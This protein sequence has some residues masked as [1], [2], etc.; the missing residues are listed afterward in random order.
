MMK[1]PSH[2]AH[3]CAEV[4]DV[5]RL[6]D[7]DGQMLSAADFRSEQTYF[8]EKLKLHNRCLHGYGV[9]CGL[10]I[11]AVTEESCCPPE[12]AE[13]LDAIREKL[14]QIEAAIDA[15]QGKLEADGLPKDEKKAILKEIAELAA[16]REALRRE[17]EGHG[18]P[19][20]DGSEPCHEDKPSAKVTVQCG[21]ALDCH[22]NEL[23][24]RQAVRV[25][26]WAVL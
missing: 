17:R 12:D 5:E 25:D 18:R 21:L 9:V 11:T 8:R 6:S 14:R 26:L 2:A 22:G 7:S 3:A 10:E 4:P 20:P 15:L 19:N 24:V 23:V 1:H 16:E 13:E